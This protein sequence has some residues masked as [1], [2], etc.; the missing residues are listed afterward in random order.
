MNLNI[1]RFSGFFSLKYLI[2]MQNGVRVKL[3]LFT[4]ER[5]S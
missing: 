5:N 1:L 3:K 4:I 2:I